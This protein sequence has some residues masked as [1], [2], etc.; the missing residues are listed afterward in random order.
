[1]LLHPSRYRCSAHSDYPSQVLEEPSSS[2]LARTLALFLSAVVLLS[3]ASFLAE[4]YPEARAGHE[5]VFAAIE[6][7]CVAIFTIEYG[8]RLACTPETLRFVFSFFNL[9]D[10]MAIGPYY[11]ELVFA[12]LFGGGAPLLRIIRLVRILRLIKLGRYVIWMRIFGVTI[13]RSA[14]PLG[15]LGFM[16]STMVIFWASVMY[17]VERGTW[18]PDVAQWVNADGQPSAF[19][20]IPAAFWW[21]I[22]SMTTV[23]YGDAYAITPLGRALSGAAII[24]GIMLTAIPISIVTA[25]LHA[26]YDRMDR[27]RALRAAHEAQP[28]PAPLAH[29]E[30]DAAAPQRLA[31][32]QAEA[33][34]HLYAASQDHGGALRGAGPGANPFDGPLHSHHGSFPSLGHEGG[35]PGEGVDGR[36]GTLVRQHSIPPAPSPSDSD[37]AARLLH[38]SLSPPFHD[39]MGYAS[40]DAA[41]G[42]GGVSGVHGLSDGTHGTHGP[43]GAPH[44]SNDFSGVSHPSSTASAPA[45]VRHSTAEAGAGH[46][47][48]S[49]S[50]QQPQLAA[51][52]KRFNWV[53]VVSDNR[54]RYQRHLVR[55]SL[56]EIAAETQRGAMGRLVEEIEDEEGA[57]GGGADAG[58]GLDGDGAAMSPN[59]DVSADLVV[60]APSGARPAATASSGDIAASLTA[61]QRTQDASSA[62][63]LAL[64]PRRG[65]LLVP[66]LALPSTN[67]ED[68]AQQARALMGTSLGAADSM[69]EA[70]PSAFQPPQAPPHRGEHGART[71]QQRIEGTSQPHPREA[72]QLGPPPPAQRPSAEAESALPRSSAEERIDASWS[73]PYLRSALQVIRGNRRRLMSSLKGLELRNREAAVEEVRDFMADLETDRV[74]ALHNSIAR[75]GLG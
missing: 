69:L 73:E 31:A 3:V 30:D 67:L 16:T 10:L 65:S 8:L 12:G 58:Q 21:A 24:T 33:A 52:R 57:E 66:R 59:G 46:L 7:A 14:V 75:T 71:F 27:M 50:G 49:H 18:D 35:L 51:H 28:P 1:M 23:G 40:A 62:G 32:E 48:E 22:I 64:A 41:D 9:V 20:S 43:H 53:H 60:H 42:L 2:P 72:T 37:L 29:L 61:R 4:S 34:A 26:E 13:E 47:Q 11:L 56:V 6:I 25:N 74:Q 39:R 70:P 38:A 17:Y 54:D 44:S 68:V 36:G 55:Q 45:G 19:S 15:M 63:A 5:R